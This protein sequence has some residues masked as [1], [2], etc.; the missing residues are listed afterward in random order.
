M[1]SLPPEDVEVV[2]DVVDDVVLEVVEL[3]VPT[4]TL[5]VDVLL[6]P[7]PVPSAVSTLFEHATTRVSGR[8]DRKG[9]ERSCIA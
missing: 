3:V 1:H 6:L 9:E 8:S 4:V 2:V 7:P 5:V